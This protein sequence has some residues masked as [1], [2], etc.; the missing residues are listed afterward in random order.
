M[1]IILTRSLNGV[2]S[3]TSQQLLIV[4]EIP[5]KYW[6]LKIHYLVDRSRP[7]DPIHFQMHPLHID[8]PYFL[9][10]IL[11]FHLGFPTNVLYAFLISRIYAT[12]SMLHLL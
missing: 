3:L 8:I 1:M 12:L 5:I 9:K 10:I 7:P 2:E 6:N 11:I 4:Q